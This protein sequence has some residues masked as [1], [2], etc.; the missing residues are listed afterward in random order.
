MDCQ[1]RVRV[2]GFGHSERPPRLIVWL[3]LF[4]PNKAFKPMPL[5]GTA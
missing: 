1:A 2:C 4:L 5:R 3:F